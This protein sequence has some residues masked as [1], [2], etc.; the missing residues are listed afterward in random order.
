MSFASLSG[1]SG[2][3]FLP[4]RELSYLIREISP[5]R[6]RRHAPRSS[7]A[8]PISTSLVMC[9]CAPNI[10]VSSTTRQPAI[11]RI[12]TD[13]SHYAQGR[14][15]DRLRLPALTLNACATRVEGA[16]SVILFKA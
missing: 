14:A 5:E 3:L 15:V 11:C 9:S 4:E 2:R 7:T 13:R 10:G 12:S 6:A 16:I 1:A 8:A